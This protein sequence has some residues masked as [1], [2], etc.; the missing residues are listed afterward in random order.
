MTDNIGVPGAVVV[1]HRCDV[2]VINIGILST[3]A[4]LLVGLRLGGGGG[5]RGRRIKLC[6]ER[7]QLGY[8]RC[9]ISFVGTGI[10]KRAYFITLFR[11]G[12]GTKG[13]M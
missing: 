8:K 4:A 10:L 5:G 13:M 9:D 6:L 2:I 1:L 11:D 7:Q 3:L 12:R